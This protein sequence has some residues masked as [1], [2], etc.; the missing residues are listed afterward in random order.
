MRERSSGAYGNLPP[1]HPTAMTSALAPHSLTGPTG[2]NDY[3]TY[4]YRN[5]INASHTASVA[6]LSGIWLA[7]F[8]PRAKDPGNT[9]DF[10]APSPLSHSEAQFFKNSNGRIR[11]FSNSSVGGE[12]ATP[13]Q[14]PSWHSH[15]PFNSGP[16]AFSGT[17]GCR[18]ICMH[19][20]SI[21]HLYDARVAGVGPILSTG[22]PPALLDFIQPRAPAEMGQ[23]VS[24]PNFADP[25]S[26]ISS[27]S[28]TT[29]R[30]SSS[31][32]DLPPQLIGHED[33][34]DVVTQPWGQLMKVCALGR[35]SSSGADIPYAV[36]MVTVFSD[37]IAYD[38][39]PHSTTVA[40]APNLSE[41]VIV[42]PEKR[43]L[44]LTPSVVNSGSVPGISGMGLE[45][46]YESSS[47]LD[48]IDSSG[49]EC[50]SSKD[51]FEAFEHLSS[52]S[53]D[54]AGSVSEITQLT[55]SVVQTYSSTRRF[56]I[57]S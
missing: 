26:E 3:A 45:S 19:N 10:R 38:S 36:D 33:T 6:H 51:E 46:A 42:T 50:C 14:T 7:V 29:M 56:E 20:N 18:L 4:H 12:S 47:T 24:V 44:S 5:H 35:F 1:Q 21:T 37:S 31:L 53:H 27:P 2:S 9:H 57:I 32:L 43:P 41:G 15:A 54:D 17:F 13:S 28:H 30:S 22:I 48:I 39:L 52:P 25:I 16:A 55:S 40:A 34:P 8:Y 49:G 11:T 23:T